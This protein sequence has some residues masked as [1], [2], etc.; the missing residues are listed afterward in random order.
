MTLNKEKFD[1]VIEKLLNKQLSCD[2][3]LNHLNSNR[4]KFYNDSK[5]CEILA[6]ISLNTSFS[7]S[8]SATVNINPSA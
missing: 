7:G 5:A 2:D 4:L 3:L 1:S 6:D 8:V